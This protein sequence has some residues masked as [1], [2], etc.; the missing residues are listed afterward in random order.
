MAS[1]HFNCLFKGPISKGPSSKCSHI[2]GYRNRTLSQEWGVQ[3]Q[4]NA[5]PPLCTE[6]GSLKSAFF[7]ACWA[8]Q[9]QFSVTCYLPQPCKVCSVGGE[10]AEECGEERS[11]HK[12]MSVFSLWSNADFFSEKVPGH[13]D[14]CPGVCLQLLPPQNKASS[15]A[16]GETQSR[17]VLLFL[18]QNA[19]FNP[20][21]SLPA[22]IQTFMKNRFKETFFKPTVHMSPERTCDHS[23][24]SSVH[25]ALNSA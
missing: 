11:T 13:S 2:L 25:Y 8:P 18:S 20:M 12:H 1:F 10:T 22:G 24:N 14:S 3:I 9:C 19:Y 4:P 7:P 6:E 17:L 5:G 21:C 15:F 16:Q 23:G